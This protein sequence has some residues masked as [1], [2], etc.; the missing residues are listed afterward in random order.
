MFEDPMQLI[1]IGIVAI[2]LLMWGPNKIPQ[3]AASLGKARREFDSARKEIQDPMNALLQSAS[4][5]TAPQPQVA[6]APASQAMLSGDEVLLKTAREMGIATEG[7]SRE[8]LSLEMVSK[9][10][11]KIPAQPTTQ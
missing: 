4:Q 6:Q 8:Q 5:T 3:L 2:A 11:Q 10:S 1:V 9:A 7:K